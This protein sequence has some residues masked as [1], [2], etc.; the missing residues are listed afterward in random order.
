MSHAKA[1][2]VGPQVIELGSGR[3][4]KLLDVIGRGGSAT[5]YR[6][7]LCSPPLGISTSVGVERA[8][9]IKLFS[10]VASDEV[11]SVHGELV[12]CARRI[13]CVDHPNVVRVDECGAWRSRP[14]VI[15]EL[16]PSIALSVFQATFQAHKRRVPP[17]LALFIGAEV[18]EALAGARTARDHDGL[19]LGIVHQALSSRDVLLSWRG[20]VK[21]TD[22]G[23]SSTRAASSAVRSVRGVT[24]RVAT[25]APEV[26]QG[27]PADARSDVFSLG[28]MLRELFVGPRF[29]AGIG[30]SDAVRLAREGYV[31]PV[32]FAPHLPE[33]L[34]SVMTRA[35]EIE[36]DARYANACAMATDLRREVF[37]M[38]VGDG[39]YFLRRA[40]ER[41]FS[42]HREEITADRD[43]QRTSGI[44]EKHG[45]APAVEHYTADLSTL[46]RRR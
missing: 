38:G 13:A 3:H 14:F 30:S 45:E 34:M 41:D 2:D 35:L 23:M 33:G 43:P 12:R 44:V 25:M 40:L 37:A 6:G 15:G 32:T 9:A 8:V 11:E 29:P 27:A 4:V 24:G 18:A 20:E 28:V 10:A 22:F 46:K 21:V 36:P 19:P 1:L 39:R 17:D 42:Q 31:H 7:V 16:I 5:V 26:A